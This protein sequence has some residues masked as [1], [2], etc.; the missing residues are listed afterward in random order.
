MTDI[1]LGSYESA[2]ITAAPGA[3]GYP[4]SCVPESKNSTIITLCVVSFGMLNVWETIFVA[5]FL[6]TARIQVTALSRL[7]QVS[8]PSW[9]DISA[10]AFKNP[11][12]PVLQHHL[13]PVHFLPPD[14]SIVEHCWN[15]KVR[16]RWLPER[17][18]ASSVFAMPFLQSH[19][20][21][22]PQRIVMRR[23]MFRIVGFCL[24]GSHKV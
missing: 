19:F 13:L 17:H 16:L 21:P 15:V 5:R 12:F 3:T 24:G 18:R 1:L 9:V 2:W 10:G 14:L 22:E 11:S 6:D 8:A 7:S 23:S 4:N 20:D